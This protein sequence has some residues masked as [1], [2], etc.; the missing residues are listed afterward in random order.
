MVFD[1]AYMEGDI[2]IMIINILTAIYAIDMKWKCSMK[3]M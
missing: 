1:G 3:F 2:T